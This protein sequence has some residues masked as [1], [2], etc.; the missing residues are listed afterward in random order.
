MCDL[1]GVKPNQK[2]E[3]GCMDNK[4]HSV[5]S[6]ILTMAHVANHHIL[7]YWA[8]ISIISGFSRGVGRMSESAYA[9]FEQALSDAT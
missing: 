8:M 5:P 9:Y 4:L 1:R 7:K 2:R 6:K 3:K